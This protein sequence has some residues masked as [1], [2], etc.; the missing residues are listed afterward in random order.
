MTLTNI[1]NGIRYVNV[2]VYIT[3]PGSSVPSKD[4]WIDTSQLSKTCSL[5]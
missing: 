1:N 2:A 3:R 4:Q 5:S